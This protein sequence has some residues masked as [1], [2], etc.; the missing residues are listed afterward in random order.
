MGKKIGSI[1]RYKDSLANVCFFS[2]VLQGF[3]ERKMAGEKV[4][5]KEVIYAATMLKHY[6]Q[7]LLSDKAILGFDDGLSFMENNAFRGFEIKDGCFKGDRSQVKGI[8]GK[9]LDFPGNANNYQYEVSMLVLSLAFPEEIG[10]LISAAK[11]A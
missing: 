6:K 2:A 8:V 5:D 3:T 10:N 4:E 11:A 9:W 7:F 1:R